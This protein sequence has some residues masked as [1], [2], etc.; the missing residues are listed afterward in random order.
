MVAWG[1]GDGTPASLSTFAVDELTG[2][3][4]QGSAITTRR[5]PGTHD[6]VVFMGDRRVL[7]MDRRDGTWR[8]VRLPG[9]TVLN[10]AG[11]GTGT[12]YWIS[13]PSSGGRFLAAAYVYPG[14]ASFA[15]WDT[16]D[17][18]PQWGSPT[19]LI[20]RAPVAQ[21]SALTVSPD[22]VAVAAAGS[23]GLFVAPIGFVDA[24]LGSDG[25]FDE[26]STTSHADGYR[27]GAR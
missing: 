27:S 14:A 3:G 6:R 2:E 10:D 8:T 4:G 5:D 13:A 11:V 24:G 15:V 21:A 19:S 20:A 12:A 22:G 17:P 25:G 18:D 7:L 26:V 16:S 9:F 23:A 1:Y